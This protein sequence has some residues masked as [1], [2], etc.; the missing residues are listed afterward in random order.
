ML[1]QKKNCCRFEKLTVN[2]SGKYSQSVRPQTVN[3]PKQGSNLSLRR[4]HA[5]PRL[6]SPLLTPLT[7]CRPRRSAT[8][9]DQCRRDAGIA[10]RAVVVGGGFTWQ[11]NGWFLVV[12]LR[13]AVTRGGWATGGVAAERRSSAKAKSDCQ[14]FK[15]HIYPRAIA[16]ACMGSPN[17]PAAPASVCSYDEAQTQ[18]RPLPL[19]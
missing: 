9:D 16:V 4:I 15:K 3:S 14:G 8:R 6:R 13:T 17:P 2:L 12:T 19:R 11:T 10:L 1:F 5:I 18:H 7:P